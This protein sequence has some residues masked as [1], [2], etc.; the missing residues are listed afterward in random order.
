MPES[1]STDNDIGARPSR[2]TTPEALA[3]WQ[4]HRFDPLRPTADQSN[5]HDELPIDMLADMDATRAAIAAA[6]ANGTLTLD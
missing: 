5:L 4:A 6:V 3:A 2:P 1:R